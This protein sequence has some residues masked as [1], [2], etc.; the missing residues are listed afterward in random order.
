MKKI[1]T[2]LTLV[3]V[4]SCLGYYAVL[5]A[6]VLGISPFLSMFY[7]MWCPALAALATYLI[8]DRSLA[9]VGW[10]LGKIKWL[11]LAYLLPLAY[12]AIAYGAIWLT[13][14]GLI[15]GQYQ[16]NFLGLVIVGTITNIAFAAGEEIGWRGLLAPELYKKMGYTASSFLTGVIWAVWHF[17]LIIAGAYLSHMPLLPQLLLLVVTLAA[18][19]FVFSWLRLISGSVWTAVLLHAS[20][21]LYVQRFFDPMTLE[22]GPL[23]KYIAGESGLALTAVFLILAVVFWSRRKKLPAS[24]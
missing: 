16:F 22:S 23:T 19:S 10:G 8:Q 7:L 1:L 17:P 18:M 21:N 12:G 14:L 4:L 13:G 24:A 6:K 15:N 9:G 5:N 3:L 11:T 2:Y 20:H